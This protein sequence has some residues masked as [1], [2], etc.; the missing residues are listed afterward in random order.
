[1]ISTRTIRTERF[2]GEHTHIEH[3]QHTHTYMQVD[4]HTC[5]LFYL[6]IGVY[7]EDLGRIGEI[8]Q[9]KETYTERD[10][11]KPRERESDRERVRK[12]DRVRR[13]S[14]ERKERKGGKK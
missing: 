12:K 9:G 2:S 10:R 8:K 4:I 13:V 11:R 1:M 5:T 6:H 7:Q 3:T 14:R